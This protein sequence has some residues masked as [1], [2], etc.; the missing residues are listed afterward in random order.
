MTEENQT[1]RGERIAKFLARAGVASRRDVERMI[2]DGRV[3]LG[4]QKVTH[5]A[6]FV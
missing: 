1:D 5:P 2:E 4:G 3:S 6:T